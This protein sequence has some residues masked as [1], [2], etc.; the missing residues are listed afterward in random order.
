MYIKADTLDDLLIDIYPRLLKSKNNISSSRGKSKELD[1]VL[2][3]LTNPLARLSRT[4]E[5]GRIFSC[6]GELLWYLSKS[7]SLP[8][9]E[10]YIGKYAKESHDGKTV[11]GGYGPRIFTMR[12][13]N[14]FTNV[15]Q[16]L[17]KKPSSRRAVIQ[18]FDAI[19][20]DTTAKYIEVPCT[21]TFQFLIR[22]NKLNMYS[23]MRSNDAYLG[24]PHDIFAFTMLQE[25]ISRSL[26]CRIGE[27]KHTVT[28]LHL[29]EGSYEK[30]KNYINEGW[31]DKVPMPS[32][33]DGDPQL[34]MEA[35]TRNELLIRTGEKVQD[36][37]NLDQYWQDLIRLLMIF[38]SIKNKDTKNIVAIK[39]RMHSPVYETY[40]KKKIPSRTKN[41]Q[42][43][44]PVT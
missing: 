4:E 29:Y 8:F 30:A 44:L 16:L 36:D 21:T 12:G 25:L 19:D 20:T 38:R 13:Q 14:Q 1:G 41:N 40:I 17:R 32:M 7:N 11:H 39:R 6:L 23:T 27:Y 35:L 18:I 3:H 42:L 22:N 43:E 33:P 15:I 37:I 10:Y 28:S 2:L 31:Q 26:N 24:L 34:A 5:R 9:I